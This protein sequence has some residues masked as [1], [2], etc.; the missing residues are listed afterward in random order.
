[1]MVTSVR[2]APGPLRETGSRR[3]HDIASRIPYH[4]GLSG[5]CKGAAVAARLNKIAAA[6]LG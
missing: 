3:V 4:T 2:I 1:M 6:R 5:R